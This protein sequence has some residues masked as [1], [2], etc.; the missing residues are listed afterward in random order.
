MNIQS[1]ESEPRRWRYRIQSQY[2]LAREQ[3]DEKLREASLVRVQIQNKE[4]VDHKIIPEAQVWIYINRVKAGYARKLAHLRHGPFRVLELVGDHAVRLETRGVE[5]DNELAVTEAD[6]VD[7]DECLLPEDGWVIELEEGEN[8][9]EE[10]MESRTGMKTRYGRQQR[11]F[12]IR[13]KGIGDP[14]WINE[15][16][17][18]C[19]A[20]L[21]T[22]ERKQTS[23]NRSKLCRFMKTRAA[24]R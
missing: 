1:Q 17:L 7:F 22:F 19:V 10:I 6:R 11:E 23:H 14:S 2:Q 13:W 15:L 21:R 20:L 12:R 8:E 5:Y 24:L 18:N 16:D 3:V 9:V 4:V